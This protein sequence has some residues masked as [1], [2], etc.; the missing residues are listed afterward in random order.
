MVSMM[1]SIKEIL[2]NGSAILVAINGDKY[3]Q[4]TGDIAR[5][6]NSK[7][8][9][10]V[11]FAKTAESW[12]DFCKK[13]NVNPRNILFIDAIS[14]SVSENPKSEE[15]HI[16]ISAPGALTELSIA[17]S[18]GLRLGVDYLIF[19]SIDLLAIHVNDVQFAKF[20]MALMSKVRSTKTRA[21]L[22]AVKGDKS[23]ALAQAKLYV[24]KCVEEG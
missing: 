21:V 6:L 5:H 18:E 23:S 14:A 1:V 7:S 4:V 16:L 17:I 13:N 2:H 8:A 10:Y 24:D 22:Y 19:D 3:Q 15:N 9:I 20:V 12:R 11:S